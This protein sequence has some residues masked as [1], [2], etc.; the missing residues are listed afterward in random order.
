MVAAMVLRLTLLSMI[1]FLVEEDSFAFDGFV[2]ISEWSA[3]WLLKLMAI[4]LS[5]PMQ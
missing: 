2:A 4:S 3:M 5:Y 1:L